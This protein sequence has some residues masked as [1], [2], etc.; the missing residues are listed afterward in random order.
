MVLK[1]IFVAAGSVLVAGAAYGQGG[2]PRTEWIECG[3]KVGQ[4]AELIGTQR[5]EVVDQQALIRGAAES[6][7]FVASIRGKSGVLKLADATTGN[8]ID[9][10]GKIE[11]LRGGG[12]PRSA[13]QPAR[14]SL[15]REHDED[16]NGQPENEGTIY[17]T[18]KSTGHDDVTLVCSS[19][20]QRN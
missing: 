6:W 1:N 2:S 9:V 10:R 4:A 7:N 20:N 15:R 19:V 13:L 3:L 5:V 12:R 11:L 17:A 8:A 18:L 14:A 16:D